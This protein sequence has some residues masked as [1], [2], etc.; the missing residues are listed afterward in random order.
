LPDRDPEHCAQSEQQYGE[1]PDLSS[2]G[3]D[4]RRQRPKTPEK[5]TA[6]YRGKK[7]THCDK[8]GVVVQAQSKRVGCLRQTS[9]GKTPDKKSVDTE[10][11]VYPPGTP[12]YQDTG[13]QGD[14]PAGG[15][16]RQP[17]KSRV[18]ATSPQRRSAPPARSHAYESESNMP[19]RE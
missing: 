16:S 19:W 12:L 5:Q 17:K 9:A 7:K 6:P 8:N 14:A 15:Q 13:F 2:D 3:T 10:P 18:R 4:R 1:P 11:S